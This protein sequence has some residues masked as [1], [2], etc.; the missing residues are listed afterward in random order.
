MSYTLEP[1]AY[2]KAILHAAKH[3]SATTI[4]LLVGQFDNQSKTILVQ[5]AIPLLHHWTDLSPMMEVAL[6]LVS[7]LPFAGC[8]VFP[9]AD[10]AR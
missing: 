1:L 10:A 2:F 3:P 6:Q 4:G 9:A 5:D 7:S 8:F